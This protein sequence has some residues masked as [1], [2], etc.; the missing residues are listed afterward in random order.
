MHGVRPAGVITELR[1]RFFVD[2]PLGAAEAFFLDGADTVE[3]SCLVGVFQCETKE[4]W[5]W[6]NHLLRLSHSVSANRNAEQSPIHLS[7][8]MIE[9]L[10]G[11]IARH[12]GSPFH[13]RVCDGPKKV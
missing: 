10:A 13:W 11:H 8:E 2:T 9:T 7:H 6:P 5:W 1:K 3:R 4:F 12:A